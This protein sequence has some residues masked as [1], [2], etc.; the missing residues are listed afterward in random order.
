M[1]HSADELIAVAYRYYSRGGCYD[2]SFEQ[3]EEHRRLVEARIQ[4][5]TGTNRDCWRALLRRIREQFPG[6]EVQNR[7][8]HLETGTFDAGYSGAIHLPLAAGEHGHSLGFLISFL[9][10]YYIIYSHRVVDDPDALKAHRESTTS[11]VVGVLVGDEW[12]F[13]PAEEADP[14]LLENE[15]KRFRRIVQSFEFS[16]EESP[17]AAW[18]SQE[19]EATFDVERMPPEI[20]KV[21]IPDVSIPVRVPGEATIYDCLFS[22]S[23]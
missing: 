3:T 14:E 2:D 1:K 20:G 8:I 13:I 11:T 7:S 18:I 16:P 4:A 12:K 15:L 23:W 19:I 17:F 5:G 21:I 10:P 9:A 22:Y 6:S